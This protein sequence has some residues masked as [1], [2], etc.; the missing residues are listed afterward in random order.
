MTETGALPAVRELYAHL[1][2]AW[3]GRNAEDF[4]ALFSADGTMIGFDG[5]AMTGR[6]IPGHLK[7][8]FADHPT[9]TY[10]A[11]VREAR[12]LG[13]GAVLLRAIAGMVPPGRRELNPALNAVQ[14]VVAE[15]HDDG[16]AVVLFQ[17]TPAQYHGRPEVVEG[18]RLEL[19]SVLLSGETVG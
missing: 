1:L 19:Q 6:Q 16:W 8:I 18:Q 7:P 9:A 14:T 13:S 10:V 2:Q 3:N 4:S 15:R 12:E 5:T 17:N 11:K